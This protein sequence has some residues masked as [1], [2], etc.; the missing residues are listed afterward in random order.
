MSMRQIVIFKLGN[1]EYGIDIMKVVEI[2]LYQAIRNVPD[3]PS[4]IEGIVNLR[5][6]IHPIYNLTKRF[7]MVQ[8]K[9][10]EHTKIIVIRTPKMNVGFI[11]DYVSE[12]FSI[13]EEDIQ[14]APEIINSQ[15]A[16]QYIQGIAKLDD[17][18]IILLDIDKL[19][20]A[21]DYDVMNK[22]IK[23]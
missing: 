11:V 6:D 1:E 14:N 10:D 18:I 19:V 12:I 20:S 8:H 4:Y 9:A 16:D 17:R 13:P 7:Q 22:I 21:K 23:A 3:A 15:A 5:G 2:V